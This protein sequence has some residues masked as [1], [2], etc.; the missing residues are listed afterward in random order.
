MLS[1]WTFWYSGVSG[2]CCAGP[3]A[4]V[5]SNLIAWPPR[6]G[7]MTSHWPFQL[8]YFA[9][10]AA[11]APPIGSISVTANANAPAELRYDIHILPRVIACLIAI[12]AT[13]TR[14]R[15]GYTECAAL[16]TARRLSPLHACDPQA[17]RGSTPYAKPTN[18]VAL[19]ETPPEEEQQCPRSRRAQ[20]YLQ[21]ASSGPAS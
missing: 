20:A 3:H 8:G 14:L 12:D 16:E 7:L 18:A 19:R 2:A 15:T 5:G 6:R 17:G 9:S 21:A 11:R 4:L 13:F 10:S 1:S